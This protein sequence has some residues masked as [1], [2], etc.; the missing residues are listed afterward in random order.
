MSV[1]TII[2]KPTL[3]CNIGCRHCYHTPEERSGEVMSLGT[4]EMIIRMASE[5]Y[6]T[7]WFVWHGGEPLMLPLK[8]YKDAIA[9][10]ERY[11][12][13]G[14]HRVSNTIQTNGILIDK[15]LMGFCKEKNINVGVSF[16]GPC[17]DMLRER[18]ADV[19]GNLDMMRER[20]HMFS[21]NATI[22]ADDTN[23][24]LRLYEHFIGNGMA[25]SLTPVILSGSATKEMI[26]DADEYAKASIDVFDRWLHDADAE[27]PLIPHLQYVMSA[28]GNPSPSDCA[29]SSC[30]TKWV[31][32]YPNG[33]LYP[34]AKGCP[35]RFRMCNITDIGRISDAF[36]SEAMMGILTASIERREKCA[37]SCSIFK[38]CNGGCSIDAL[39]EGSMS[40]N[41]GN[42]CRI[43]KKVFT[44]I[45]TAVEDILKE[46]PDLS[47]YNRFMRE[48]IVEKLINPKVTGV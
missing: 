18:T 13:K 30:L 29:H 1:I 21:V 12:G 48:I 47:Q 17:N 19:Q 46:R 35:S 31:S 16:E 23:D 24:Q 15:K 40:D 11:F 8:F 9:L 34:C 6:E 7:V 41:G 37:A 27:M 42:S 3:S 36:R 22:C 28:L 25:L 45:L 4:L 32:V 33:D 20:G 2:I 43:F 14:S 26:P 10:Q 5:E 39:S 38:Y 44:H